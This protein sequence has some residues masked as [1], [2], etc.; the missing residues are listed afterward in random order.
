[1]KKITLLSLC[2]VL[3]A[4][5]SLFAGQ[6]LNTDPSFEGGEAVWGKPFIPA[7]SKDRGSKLSF[8]TEDPHSGNMCAVMSADSNSRFAFAP[9][10]GAMNVMPGQTFDISIWIKAAADFKIHPKTPGFIIRVDML[11]G[12]ASVGTVYINASGEASERLGTTGPVIP[13]TWTEVKGQATVPEGADR[14]RVNVFFW[15]ASGT[16]YLDDFEV[17]LADS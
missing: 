13:T 17:S 14:M 8:T 6:P 12:K 10:G 15:R 2:G 5:S 11:K 9:K 1:M 4:T 7:D 3:A 16:L